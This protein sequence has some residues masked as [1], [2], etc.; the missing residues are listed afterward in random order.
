[1]K[2]NSKRRKYLPSILIQQIRLQWHKDC[3]GGNAAAQRTQ[4]PRAMQLP[5]DFFTSY[6]PFG[7][8][9]HFVFVFQKP[10]G[11]QIESDYH[12]LMRWEAD[13]TMSLEPFEL[14]QQEDGIQV[15]YRYDWHSGAMPER[16]TY[17]KTGQKLPLNEL[18]LTDITIDKSGCYG[19]FSL[20][21]DTGDSP[22][23][24]LY[25]NVSFDEQFVP[26]QKVGYDTF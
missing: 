4:Y 19:T 5:K 3:R 25:L 13:D 14:I 16:Y 11:F 22:A 17:D 8:P 1:M 9:T 7:P 2:Q 12:R 26:S 23:G 20:C 10:D 21:Y 15:R 24:E 6:Y 18:A